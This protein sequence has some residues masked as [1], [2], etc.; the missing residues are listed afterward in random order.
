MDFMS[1][2]FADGRRFRVLNVIDDLSREC[3]AIEVGTSLPGV[4]VT[5]VL[6]R[7]AAVRDAFAAPV[8]VGFVNS[9]SDR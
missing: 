7:I 4:V 1:D 5:R 8:A 6:D 2:A 3:L 9:Q